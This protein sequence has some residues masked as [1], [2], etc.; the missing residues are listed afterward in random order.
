MQSVGSEKYKCLLKSQLG[1]NYIHFPHIQVLFTAIQRG[2]ASVF[3]QE[4]KDS[5][6]VKTRM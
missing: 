1:S 2:S 4:P 3:I 5:L 6:S